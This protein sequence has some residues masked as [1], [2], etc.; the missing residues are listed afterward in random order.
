MWGVFHGWI[1]RNGSTSLWVVGAGGGAHFWADLFLFRPKKAPRVCPAVP[2]PS[3]DVTRA[4]EQAWTRAFLVGTPGA[5][6]LFKERPWCTGGLC[7]A[8]GDKQQFILGACD[9]CGHAAKKEEPGG[10]PLGLAAP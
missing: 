3:L 10:L 1:Q 2:P 9:Y 8:P 5:Q 6:E 7:H 4:G